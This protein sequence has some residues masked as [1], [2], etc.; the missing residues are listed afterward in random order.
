[1]MTLPPE[2]EPIHRGGETPRWSEWNSKFKI[3]NSKLR[4]QL[5]ET[6]GG[7]KLNSEG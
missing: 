3:Q 7:L 5:K 4:E 1:M 6:E 2:D